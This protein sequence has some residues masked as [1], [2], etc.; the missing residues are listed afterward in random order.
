MRSSINAPIIHLEG[1]YEL[2]YLSANS[3]PS[4]FGGSYATDSE[5]AVYALKRGLQRTQVAFG[6]FSCP[7]G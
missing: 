6:C 4:Q 1:I 2:M 3:M 7:S 5:N